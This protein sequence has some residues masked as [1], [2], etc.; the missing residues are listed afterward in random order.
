MPIHLS[1][2]GIGKDC[3][4]MDVGNASLPHGTMNHG[5]VPK[6]TNHGRTLLLPS[7]APQIR[8]RSADRE[9]GSIQADTNM[10]PYKR[11]CIPNADTTDAAEATSIVTESM[12]TEGNRMQPFRQG[13][14]LGSSAPCLWICSLNGSWLFHQAPIR[15]RL[16]PFCLLVGRLPGGNDLAEERLSSHADKRYSTYSLKL[17]AE[18]PS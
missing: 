15:S 5:S 12:L 14:C 9:I 7:T 3:H 10:M 17:A 13:A 4:S 1:G 16:A 8:G 18:G 2:T 11:S 6:T